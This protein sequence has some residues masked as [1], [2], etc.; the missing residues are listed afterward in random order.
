MVKDC[1]KGR[2]L[3]ILL[4]KMSAYRHR[5]LTYMKYDIEIS[6]GNS[7]EKNFDE[8]HSNEENSN[9]ENFNE[10]KLSLECN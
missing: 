3:C 7:D 5:Y 9:E 8:K 2:P 1:K 10:K 6:S 4:P